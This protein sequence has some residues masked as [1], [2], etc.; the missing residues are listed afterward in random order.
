MW[1]FVQY[2]HSRGIPA[3][4]ALH[5]TRWMV[6]EWMRADQ[7]L[8]G[9]QQ[10]VS[11]GPP[12]HPHEEASCIPVSALPLTLAPPTSEDRCDTGKLPATIVAASLLE[13]TSSFLALV[14]RDF[15]LGKSSTICGTNA[16]ILGRNKVNG[17]G[18]RE[19]N[20]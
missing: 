18:R 4:R 8:L 11:P 1:N 7:R 12:L 16:D 2:G 13:H 14:Q 3:P 5:G 17:V 6:H 15:E 9:D 20:T 10:C 19:V